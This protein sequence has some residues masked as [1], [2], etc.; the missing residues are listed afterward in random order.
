M[1]DLSLVSS[2]D[3]SPRTFWVSIFV[4]FLLFCFFFFFGA[5]G[6]IS[7][8]SFSFVGS[9]CVSHSLFHS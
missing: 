5:G 9:S 4:K 3:G 8:F 7:V 6:L 2:V 1:I